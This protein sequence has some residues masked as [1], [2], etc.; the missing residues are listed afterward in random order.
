MDF[1]N[2][3]KLGLL[4][5]KSCAQIGK[6][7]P[8][9]IG[10]IMK[11]T[12]FLT[13]ALSLQASASLLAQR[14]SLSVKSEHLKTVLTA[15]R[16][17]SDYSFIYTDHDFKNTRPVSIQARNKNILDI[18]PELFQD[19]PLTYVIDGKLIN[20]LP[21]ALA[22]K[23]D[24]KSVKQNDAELVQTQLR[25]V[26][27]IV[28]ENGRPLV[29]VSISVQGHRI[30]AV[31]D[32]NGDFSIQDAPLNA[33]LQITY[34]GYQSRTIAAKANMG[35]I[36]L[37][38]QESVLEEAAVQ[39]NTGYQTVSRERMTGSFGYISGE[40]LESKLATGLK[41]ALEGQTT[42]LVIDK[43]GNV[44]IR[45][46]STFSAQM[47]PLLVVD[48]Y[49]VESK[50]EDLNPMNIASI[51]VLKDGVAAS[52]YGSRAA[53]GVIVVTTKG[54]R[55]GKP[56]LSYSGFFHAIPRP[57]LNR[58][59]KASTADYI[60]AEIELF[61]LDP[62][63]ASPMDP[64]NMSRV[65]YLLMQV[66]EGNITQGQADAEIAQLKTVDGLKQV[67]RAFFRPEIN[68]Q[69]NIGINGGNE[70]YKY[71]IAVNY[72]GSQKNM[73]NN[74]GKRLTFDLK[75]EWKPF[76]FLTAGASAN[77][78]VDNSESS[79]MLITNQWGSS[80]LG[81][82]FSSL[83]S[84]SLQTMLQPYTDLWDKNGNPA[85]IWGLSQYKEDTYRNTSGMKRW[86]YN[87]I[88]D[89]DKSQ[90]DR[91]VFSTRISGFL[92]A[93]IFKDLVAEVGG[94]WER[95]NTLVKGLQGGD[96]YDMRI[97]Y[98]D[99]TSRSN[100]AMHYLP[101]GG[102][103]NENRDINES[104]TL[105]SQLNYN[106]VFGS[107]KHRFN[108]LL[109]NEV[110]KLTFDN[111]KLA[112][113]FGYNP[114]AGS[115]IPVNIKDYL[116]GLY[117]PDM[118]FE[119][120]F[121]GMTNG[122]FQYRDTRFVSWYGNSSYE[123]DNR[124]ILSGSMRL[125]LTNFFG[126]SKK[127]RYR[128]MWSLGG[129]YKLSNEK[130]WDSDLLN[131]LFIRGSYGVNGNI[132]LNN[133][134]SL[135]LR[136]GNYSPTT[137]GIP[138]NV[139]SPPNDQL[140]WEKTTISNVGVDFGLFNSRIEGSFDYYNKESTDLLT[141]DAIDP[142][143]GYNSLTRNVGAMRNHGLELSINATVLEGKDFR[144]TMMPNISLNINKV[145][146]YR[147]N[148]TSPIQ[149][150]TG[151]G[152]LVE[153]YPATGLW[154]YRFAGLNDLG[155]TQVYN[156]DNQVILIGG[157]KVPDLAYQGTLRPKWD[158]ALTNSFKY[159]DLGLSFMFIAKLG[160]KYRKDG[161][162]GSNIQ[163]R[164]V[165]ERWDPNS[166]TN[167]T[168]Y[169][170]LQS[171]N[172]DMFYFPY[173]DRLIG[174]ASYAKLRDLTLTYDLSKYTKSFRIPNAQLYFQGR[175]LFRITAKGVDIDPETAE[176]NL[177]GGATYE[178]EQSFSSLPLPREFFMGVRI[179]F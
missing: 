60:D 157:S 165:A 53:N 26:G 17:Q 33:S 6:F 163:N 116:G 120:T 21:K 162:A 12:I 47:T 63:A 148:R 130:F 164:H 170:V 169:P 143:F 49:P 8:T 151:G 58:L 76:S 13:C 85:S 59:N 98:N 22:G 18:L 135:I 37:S 105:R 107:N 54:G 29:G 146:Y 68:H 10:L 48:G 174:N 35:T 177:T 82:T 173:I 149:L 72:L 56:K 159:K 65:T 50:L 74:E 1:K 84:W 32:T 90:F 104:W 39:I 117:D 43:S 36:A 141:A 136:T 42:G 20:I 40:Q 172:M 94:N 7:R 175:N 152:V 52:I 160:H 89:F 147:V 176:L 75:N 97:A 137:G 67:E 15:L 88:E 171:W 155:Q 64:Y 109:G 145:D 133:G 9:C 78:V 71:N 93:Q 24:S 132:S 28:D 69:H 144:W 4:F 3:D 101:D 153:G 57:N 102:V 124:F 70:E 167:N 125:D 77:V 92:R 115:F 91:K 112:S 81:Y 123:Y 87:P 156:K 154:G 66:R 140:R 106:T 128:P 79:N 139:A 55:S 27:K 100:P 23:S 126:T 34:V 5:I 142:T 122:E 113:R 62:D 80:Y 178:I 45:G 16:K 114:I 111:N 138:Y 11:L 2:F 99:A 14:V 103:I 61:N 41:N 118:M 150:T 119:A 127:Y 95:G 108:A 30:G 166:T 110:R 31:T 38:P 161:F 129:T 51:T 19:Q 168:I 46:V 96:A 73:I 25:I 44:E 158:M 121:P 134:P 131:K 179:S 83:T 86:D